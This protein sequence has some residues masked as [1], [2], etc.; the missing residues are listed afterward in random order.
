MMPGALW[1]AYSR[2]SGVFLIMDFI[3]ICVLYGVMLHVQYT[4]IDQVITNFLGKIN[5]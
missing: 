2:K 5:A 4:L 1:R 3:S